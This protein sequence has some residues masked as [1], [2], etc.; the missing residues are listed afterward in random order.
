MTDM[1]DQRVARPARDWFAAEAERHAAH[2]ELLSDAHFIEALG[3]RLANAAMA[4]MWGERW[5]TPLAAEAR[6]IG[7]ALRCLAD[8]LDSH[9]AK[10]G[11]TAK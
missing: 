1:T 10:L 7:E 11:D 5:P 4:A 8:Q 6:S 9:V 3:A 2:A